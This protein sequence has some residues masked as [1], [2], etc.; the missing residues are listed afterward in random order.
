MAVNAIRQVL[1]FLLYNILLK[2]FDSSYSSLLFIFFVKIFFLSI[3]SKKKYF[4]F[5]LKK[6]FFSNFL[7]FI[8]FFFVVFFFLNFHNFFHVCIFVHHFNYYLPLQQRILYSSSF[9]FKKNQKFFVFLESNKIPEK[10]SNSTVYTTFMH[11]DPLNTK[12]FSS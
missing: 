4:N 5:Y 6:N 10:K 11:K 1:I 8:Y 3:F 12:F 7:V 2:N 9:Y